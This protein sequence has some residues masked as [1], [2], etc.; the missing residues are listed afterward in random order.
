MTVNEHRTEL[1][2]DR[3]NF[4][5]LTPPK[6]INYLNFDENVDKKINTNPVNGVLINLSNKVQH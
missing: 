4:M 2:D 6:E 3:L 5:G 1:Y